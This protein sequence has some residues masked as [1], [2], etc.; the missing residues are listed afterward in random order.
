MIT[1]VVAAHPDD[2][3]FGMGAVV[4]GLT[5]PVCV[6]SF[7]C[8][9]A[10]REE[11]LRAFKHLGVSS[12]HVHFTSGSS[13]RELIAE[14]DVLF[15]AIQ[16]DRVFTHFYGDSHQE[17]RLVYDCVIASLRSFPAASCLVWENNQPGAM[18]QE[19]FSPRVF[20]PVSQ[21]HMNAKI[22]ALREHESQMKKYDTEQLFPFLY[23]AARRNGY[24][25]GSIYAEAFF[26]IKLVLKL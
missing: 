6:L 21:E 12:D 23:H 11:A 4:A 18:T 14:Y 24:L 25:C 17:H 15:K 10:R 20:F 2:I 8:T 16:P 3:E 26:P 19:T 7:Q 13:Y 9:P 22:A 5:N 1:L